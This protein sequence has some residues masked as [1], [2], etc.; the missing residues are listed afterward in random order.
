MKSISSDN[1]RQ[2]D[3]EWI[4]SNHCN[5]E[6][7][8][9]SPI[10]YG[11]TTGWPSAE[12]GIKFVKEVHE[13]INPHEKVITLNGGEPTTWPEL[14]QFLENIEHC[15]VGIV[16]NGSRTLRWWEKLSK[17]DKVTYLT[18]SIHL[19]YADVEHIS[20]VIEIMSKT[21]RV[22]VL[23]LVCKET[24]EIALKFANGLKA[25]DLTCKIFLK[26][27]ENR[28]EDTDVSDPIDTS[29]LNWKYIKENKIAKGSTIGQNWLIDDKLEGPGTGHRLVMQNKARFKGWSCNIIK[30][31]LVINQFGDIYG[32]VCATAKQYCI[33]NINS[34]GII[35]DKIPDLPVI[36]QDDFCS[37]IPDIRIPKESKLI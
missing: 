17:L 23:I 34:S 20:N 10:I 6:C 31:R 14:F 33:G 18:L 13:K 12:S 37:C 16:S 32:A 1:P 26:K 15:D 29:I 28:W 5:Y 3:I 8:Y 4:L 22:A 30:H 2:I 25:K 35:L 24:S 27:I 19:E 7:T 11:N 9:C 36:C 21:A